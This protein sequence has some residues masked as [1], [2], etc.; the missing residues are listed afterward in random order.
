MTLIPKTKFIRSPDHLRFVANFPCIACQPRGFF[1]NLYAV[2]CG[3][4]F[5][6]AQAQAA[7]MRHIAECGMGLKPS[8]EWTLPLCT[9][10]KRGCH[11]AHDTNPDLFWRGWVRDQCMRLAKESPDEKIRELLR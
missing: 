7:H 3:A 11:E 4:V 1:D 5:S 9:V 2:Q 8:D 10:D 6:D